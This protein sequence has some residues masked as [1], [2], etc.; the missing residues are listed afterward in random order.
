MHFVSQNYSLSAEEV[1]KAHVDVMHY[2]PQAQIIH[3]KKGTH[4]CHLR[5]KNW[6]FTE[7]FL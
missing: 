4:A 3:E 6:D 1:L 5:S 7:L 2:G